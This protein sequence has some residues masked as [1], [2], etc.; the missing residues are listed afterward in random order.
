MINKVYVYTKDESTTKRAFDFALR[1]TK[2]SDNLEVIVRNISSFANKKHAE[3]DSVYA[4]DEDTQ[5]RICGSELIRI[6]KSMSS[7]KK[8]KTIKDIAESLS[9]I[10]N[11]KPN[12]ISLLDITMNSLPELIDKNNIKSF[13]EKYKNSYKKPM[14]IKTKDGKTI[15]VF[16][17]EEDFKGHKNKDNILM[18]ID[19]YVMIMFI[20][21]GFNASSIKIERSDDTIDTDNQKSSS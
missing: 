6:N 7:E 19:E 11:S 10:G 21:L 17:S 12:N 3:T 14:L 4:T 9:K 18:T 16:D 8:L 5:S 1:A 15:A 13:I 20:A 2:N